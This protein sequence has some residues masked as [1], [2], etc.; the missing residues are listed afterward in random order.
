MARTKKMIEEIIKNAEY[1]HPNNDM[2]HGAWVENGNQYVT[3]GYRMVMV[4]EPVDVKERDSEFTLSVQKK[5]D[6][7]E[8]DCTETITLPTVKE[9]R[10]QI[11]ELI[12]K[13]YRSEGVCYRIGDSTDLAVVN[14]KYLVEC[15]EA[16]GATKIKYNPLKPRMCPLYMETKI[17]KAILCPI[18]VNIDK[19]GFW[20][21]YI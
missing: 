17:G 11:T 19:I 10:S 20:K 8:H 6:E 3:D 13:R 9:I 18:A 5:I 21:R 12:G 7:L 14:A 15:M 4:Y 1:A 2:Y 16:I